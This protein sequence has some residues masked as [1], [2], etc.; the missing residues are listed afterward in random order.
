MGVEPTVVVLLADIG[1]VDVDDSVDIYPE[2]VSDIVD[3]DSDDAE[4][5]VDV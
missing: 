3:V 4:A 2:V 1:L 5:S